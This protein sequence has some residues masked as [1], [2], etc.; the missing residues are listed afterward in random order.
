[1]QT[2]RPVAYRK[3]IIRN[4]DN[5]EQ[6]R[7][8]NVSIEVV[9]LCSRTGIK[10]VNSNEHERSMVVGTIRGDVL[11]LEDA[12]VGGHVVAVSVAVCGRASQVT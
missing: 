12:H 4:R 1:M 9:N 2:R 11:S 3:C 7:L 6:T 5:P 8:V 10:Q